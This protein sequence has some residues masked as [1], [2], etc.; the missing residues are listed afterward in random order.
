MWEDPTGPT[1]LCLGV[2]MDEITAALVIFG[3]LWVA[4]LVAVWGLMTKIDGL[5]RAILYLA[6]QVSDLQEKEENRNEQ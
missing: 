2:S 5:D 3:V 1:L 6:Q 4:L